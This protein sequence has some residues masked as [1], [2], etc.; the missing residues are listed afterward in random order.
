MFSPEE[1]QWLIKHLE[2]DIRAAAEDIELSGR[3]KD[4]EMSQQILAKLNQQY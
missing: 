1:K 2:E 4:L 3:Y